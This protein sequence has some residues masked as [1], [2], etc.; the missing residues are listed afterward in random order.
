VIIPILKAS[1]GDEKFQDHSQT[2]GLFYLKALYAKLTKLEK[3][4]CS[5][6]QNLNLGP[7]R[8]YLIKPTKSNDER[9]KN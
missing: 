5:L 3:V 1:Y 2:C 4:D 7:C 6:C 8:L 9:R